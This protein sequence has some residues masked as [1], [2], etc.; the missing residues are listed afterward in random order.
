M[1]LSEESQMQRITYSVFTCK[2]FLENANLEIADKGCLGLTV[3]TGTDIM[4][5]WGV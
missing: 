2:K 3:G 4:K 1:N 5:L